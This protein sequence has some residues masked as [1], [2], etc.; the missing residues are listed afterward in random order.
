MMNAP[1]ISSRADWIFDSCKSIVKDKDAMIRNLIFNMLNK[2][3]KLFK[4]KNLPET[5]PPKDLETILQVGGYAIITEVKGDL[6]AFTGGLGGKPNPYYLP[7]IATVSNPALNYTSNLK[8]DEEC[9][10][11]LNDYY[12]QSMMPSY[13]KYAEMLAD[14]EISLRYA[15]INGRIPSIVQA[16]NE[17]SYESAKQFFETIESGQSYGVVLTNDFFDGITTQQY[18]GHD[19]IKPLIEAIQY[20]KGSWYNEIGL[21]AAFNMKREAINEAEATLNENI[22]F[23]GIESELQCRKIGLDKVNNMYGTNISVE[24]D[25]VWAK[26]L[27]RDVLGINIQEAEIAATYAQADDGGDDNDAENEDEQHTDE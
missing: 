25:S 24:F 11:I 15:I 6:Y 21:N 1:N 19:F 9:V 5:I 2:T 7:T 16:D 23:P 13:S 12:Y 8:I 10:V 27:Y 20:I 17:N 3:N 14:A 22:L 26:N 4:Y 18:Y